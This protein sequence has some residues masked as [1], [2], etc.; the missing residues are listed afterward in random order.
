MHSIKYLVIPAITASTVLLPAELRDGVVFIEAKIEGSQSEFDR[1][2]ID[3]GS[4]FTWVF[5]HEM[6]REKNRERAEAGY[7]FLPSEEVGG[8]NE[9]ETHIDSIIPIG[10]HRVGY[11][12]GAEVELGQWTRKKFIVNGVHEWIQKFG[13]VKNYTSFGAPPR[14]SGLI[15]ASPASDFVKSH[16][17]FGFFPVGNSKP[18]RVPYSQSL[19]LFV[20]E[21]VVEKCSGGEMMYTSITSE[22]AYWEIKGSIKVGNSLVFPDMAMVMDTGA[23]TLMFPEQFVEDFYASLDS[24]K[25]KVERSEGAAGSFDCNQIE[26][27]PDIEILTPAGARLVLRPRH[28][29]LVIGQLCGLLIVSGSDEIPVVIG[30][31]LF[32]NFAVEFDG[33]N[34]RI[35]FCEVDKQLQK[36]AHR[37]G[38]FVG[39][40]LQPQAGDEGPNGHQRHKTFFGIE[41]N[42]DTENKSV[43]R[44]KASYLLI[45]ASVAASFV[46]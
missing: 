37:H 46:L 31:P 45:F 30:G 17:K 22:E 24:S 1:L 23:S 12:D 4:T 14:K 36:P 33:G 35:G 41:S 10:G 38:T 43:M 9:D 8:I 44:N 7:S 15:G 27:L 32:R 40:N 6:R 2:I 13:I 18:V 39:I 29:T 34:K 28:Y 19:N 3:T 42:P 11:E 25:I 26:H 21:M 16:P 20:G 5:P